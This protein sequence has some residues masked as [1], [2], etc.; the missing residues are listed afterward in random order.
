MFLLF[1]VCCLCFLCVS[2]STHLM[3]SLSLS[4][5]CW[6]VLKICCQPTLGNLPFDISNVLY[7]LSDGP[8]S[9]GCVY[10]YVRVF[11]FDFHLFTFIFCYLFVSLSASPSLPASA[12][13]SLSQYLS[14][15]GVAHTSNMRIKPDIVSVGE[16]D[17][18][19]PRT[20]GSNN[21]NGFFWF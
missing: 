19:R 21:T 15:D 7:S 9:S 18:L 14:Q 20:D 12:I 2:E 10:V 4:P 1:D 3:K 6:S 13:V 17:G 11:L 5:S 8:S 16:F